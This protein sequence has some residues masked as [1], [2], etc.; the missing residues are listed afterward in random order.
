MKNNDSL[1]Y[2]IFN[3]HRK[4]I[5]KPHLRRG[6]IKNLMN[7][8]CYANGI[9]YGLGS[10]DTEKYVDNSHQVE[11]FSTPYWIFNSEEDANL[12]LLLTDD[13][14]VKGKPVWQITSFK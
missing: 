3:R 11:V 5:N 2:L 8:V 7:K 13:Y 6:E 10:I 1:F 12:A 14:F 4:S 9:S